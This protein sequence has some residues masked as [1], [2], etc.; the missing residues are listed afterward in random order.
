MTLVDLLKDFIDTSKERL[1]N[2][3]TGAFI[4]SFV[5]FNW[6]LFLE[7]FFSKMAIEDRMFIIEQEYVNKWTILFPIIMAFVYTIGLPF[8]MVII[9]RILVYPTKNRLLNKYV[10]K[11]DEVEEKI[12][13]AKKVLE[14]KN[15][16]SGNKEKQNFIDQIEELKSINN[17]MLKTHKNTIEILNNKLSEANNTTAEFMT[18]K[19]KSKPPPPSGY[20]LVKDE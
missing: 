2:P 4:W 13:L 10:S 19:T 9:D 6:Q 16:E 5:I 12:K 1:K 7:L 14:L 18:N 17:E 3:I 8:L 20:T 15:A 11:I